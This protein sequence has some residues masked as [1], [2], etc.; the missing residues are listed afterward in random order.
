MVVEVASVQ[1]AVRGLELIL[2]QEGV[3]LLSRLLPGAG[4]WAALRNRL[5]VLS[6]TFLMRGHVLMLPGGVV[7]ARSSCS[8]RSSNGSSS[9]MSINMDAGE[10]REAFLIELH[11]LW[12]V[13]ADIHKKMH[14]NQQHLM[15]YV[16]SLLLA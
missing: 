6:A 1:E 13:F 8:S 16:Q 9:S 4:Q 2:E 15:G 5:G 7:C 11:S 14:T 12:V 3:E 10:E